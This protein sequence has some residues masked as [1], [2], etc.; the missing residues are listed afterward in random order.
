MR[1]WGGVGR[2][3]ALTT[4]AQLLAPMASFGTFLTIPPF[5]TVR[6]EGTRSTVRGKDTSSMV[7]D[8]GYITV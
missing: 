8:E 4:A 5:S 3:A 2:R 7:G 6:D 1:G